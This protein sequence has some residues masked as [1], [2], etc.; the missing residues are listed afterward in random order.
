EKGVLQKTDIQLMAREEEEYEKKDMKGRPDGS[1][2]NFLKPLSSPFFPF[3]L[4]SEK[5]FLAHTGFPICLSNNSDSMKQIVSVTLNSFQGLDR[6]F[7]EMLKQ[8]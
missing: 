7:Y 1:F 3:L 5:L 2:E 6:R 4:R 8:Y